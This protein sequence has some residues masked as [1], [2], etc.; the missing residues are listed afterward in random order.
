MSER[1][2]DSPDAA[3]PVT[4]ADSPPRLSARNRREVARLFSQVLNLAGAVAA[5]GLTRGELLSVAGHD[6]EL[7]D[8]LEN[9]RR[10]APIR[11]PPARFGRIDDEPGRHYRGSMRFWTPV[12]LGSRTVARGDALPPRRRPGVVS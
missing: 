3:V 2:P 8:A 1:E 11:G 6:P 7:A 5:V 10:R 9:A 12:A 4:A